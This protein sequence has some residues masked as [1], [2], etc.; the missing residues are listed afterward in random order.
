MT[1]TSSYTYTGRPLCCMMALKEVLCACEVRLL[2]EQPISTEKPLDSRHLLR[3]IH[4]HQPLAIGF[5]M[6]VHNARHLAKAAY[7]SS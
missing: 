6:L 5:P 2:L 7:I 3:Q 1:A 4:R